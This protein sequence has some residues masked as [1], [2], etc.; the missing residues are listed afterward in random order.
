MTDMVSTSSTDEGSSTS[1]D[2]Q[3]AVRYE[4]D[5]R[6]DRHPHPRRPDRE[7]QHD[8]RALPATRCTPPSTGCTTRWTTSPGVVVASAKKTFFAGGNLKLM[9]Q[10]GAGRRRDGLRG[11]EAIK[12]DLRR[13]EKFPRPV[14][15]AINGAALGGGL[16]IALACHHRIVV[17]DPSAV[18][19]LPEATLGLLPG[20]GGVTR[21]VRMLGLQS[22][23]DGRAA[24]GHPV[25]AGRRAGQ[26]PRR[27]GRRLA[28]R[29]ARRPRRRGSSS[30]ATTPRP[31]RNPWDRAGLPDARRHPAVA[32][33]RGL[34]AG[35]PGAAAQADQGCR[36]TPPSARSCR[37]RSRVR[38]S[39]SRPPAGSSRRYLT[40][41]D[42]RPE[43][44]EHD[45]GVLLR[46]AGD[47]RRQAPP[48]GRREVHA[49]P[50]SPSSAPG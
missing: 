6:R 34:P 9:M 10:A 48:R 38:R 23:P 32:E 1:E 14:V 42:R 36:S 46:P 20:G 17:D 27:R 47:Q 15:A 22:G 3:T 18:V 28:R 7:R 26:G 44:Q 29:P 4:R 19:G 5:A 41:A 49:P 13:L 43:L 50:R 31:P 24:P 40:D 37:P 8:E 33:A 25:Q 12:A 16:E 11:V 35:V 39:T 30:T 21:I 45:P 2:S